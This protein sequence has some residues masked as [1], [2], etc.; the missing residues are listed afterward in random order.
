[1]NPME[2]SGAVD[3]S[4]DSPDDRAVDRSA[5]SPDDGRVASSWSSLDEEAGTVQLTELS[6]RAIA[7]YQKQAELT[8]RLWSYFGSNSM[9][10]TLVALA[11]PVFARMGWLPTDGVYLRVLLGLAVVAYYAFCVGNR[12]ALEVSQ[13]A[14]ERIAAQAQMASGIELKVIRPAKALLF[15]RVVSLMIA[16]IMLTGFGIALG[17]FGSV[18]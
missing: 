12:Q 8:D 10:A 7:L 4:E 6:V 16:V 5:D 14:L 11:A 1:M 2:P 17:I 9:F 13:E 15:H 3:R 18:S